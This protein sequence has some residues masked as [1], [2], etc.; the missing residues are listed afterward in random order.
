MNILDAVF[1]PQYLWAI[2]GLVLL[3]SELILPG[4]IIFFFGLGALVTAVL[5][6]IIPLTINQQ[7]LIF[8]ISSLML[9]IGLRRW[10][11][12]IFTGCRDKQNTARSDLD[13]LTGMA[14]TVR[15]IIRPGY[16][17]KVE[18]NGTDWQ[19][20][21][22]ETIAPGERVVVTGQSNLVLSVKKKG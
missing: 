20:E 2:G 16:L 4:L 13:E 3:L 5:C 11:K 7:L 22:D 21:S 14:A 9:L 12:G 6:W 18:L 10:L 8:L 17:G 1:Q 15:E 19:A